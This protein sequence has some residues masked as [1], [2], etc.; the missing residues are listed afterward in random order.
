MI[1]HHAADADPAGLGQPFETR[2]HI[3]T[4]PMDVAPILDDVADID[5]HAELDPAAWW[6][7]G[8]SL[9]HLTLHFYGASHCVDDAGEFEKQAIARRFDDPA[10]MFLDLRIGEFAADRLQRSKG[11]FLVRPHEPRVTR[12]IS[13]EN[14][15]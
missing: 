9:C 1:T 13:G 14:G 2:C 8:V 15:G 12:Y 4:I 7:I 3:D 6:H 5:P 11:A 10:A